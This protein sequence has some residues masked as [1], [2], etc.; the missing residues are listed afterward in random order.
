MRA[1]CESGTGRI[2]G[3]ECGKIRVVETRILREGWDADFDMKKVVSDCPIAISA[4]RAS[5]G[6]FWESEFV[7][8]V[9]VFRVYA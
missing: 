9:S 6:L 2:R 7:F 4:S 1:K 8:R 3:R 5:E